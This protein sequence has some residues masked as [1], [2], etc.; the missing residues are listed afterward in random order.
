[1]VVQASGSG[2]GE[3]GPSRTAAWGLVGVFR[4]VL[5]LAVSCS[6]QPGDPLFEVSAVALLLACWRTFC[7]TPEAALSSGQLAALG[8]TSFF[9]RPFEFPGRRHSSRK[10]AAS[11]QR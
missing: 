2:G 7:S 1:V 5:A 9:N 10:I 8:H 3:M 11:L 4:A 6:M